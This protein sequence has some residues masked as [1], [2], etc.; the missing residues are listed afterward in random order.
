VVGRSKAMNALFKVKEKY[1][2]VG[3]SILKT[4]FPGKL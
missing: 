4:F 3:A 2:H 1:P